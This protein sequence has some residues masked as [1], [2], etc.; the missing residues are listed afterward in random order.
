[1]T[2]PEVFKLHELLSLSTKKCGD[3]DKLEYF[4]GNLDNCHD[5]KKVMK[6]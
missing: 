2:E 3:N 1:M 4:T 5:T 6:M